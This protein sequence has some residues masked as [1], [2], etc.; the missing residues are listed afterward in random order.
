MPASIVTDFK[1]I[2]TAGPT[3]DGRV[4][5]AQW[6]TDMAETYDPATY[7]A[8]IWIDHMR[9]AS[10]GTV[11]ELKVKEERGVAKLYAKIS[12]SRA[13]IQMNQVWEESLFFSIEP[14]EDFAKTGKCYLTGLGMTDSPAS[15][16]TD[17]MRFAA[18]KGREFTARYAGE[19]VPD[20]REKPHDEEMERFG[21]TFFQKLFKAFKEDNHERKDETGDDPMNTEQ[22]NTVKGTLEATQQAVEG[23][24]ETMQTFM[25]T[26][27]VPGG[28]GEGEAGGEG[29]G[30]GD[31]P[32][33]PNEDQ[34]A[35]LKKNVE[36]M[37]NAF[38]LMADRMEKAAPGTPFRESHQPAGEV[39]DIL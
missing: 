14:T 9:Y 34:F 25:A 1:C 32:A 6:L 15:L 35:E 2:A 39:D 5:E 26:F 10:Y 31:T 29:E 4:I 24:A 28:E 21:K 12:P 30:G 27:K 19:R 17:E 18:I 37:S 3:V 7:T 33:P 13:L 8:M 38:S 22:F 23:M 36:T 11:R 16:G 20:L